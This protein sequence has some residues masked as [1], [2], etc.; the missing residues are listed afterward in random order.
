MEQYINSAVEQF[1]AVL[2]EQI[3]RQKRM[4]S[5]NGA[6][7]YQS[8]PKIIIGICYGDGIGPI[9]SKESK[10]LLEFILKDEIA[11]QQKKNDNTAHI[12]YAPQPN[13]SNPK[14]QRLLFRTSSL[15][16]FLGLLFKLFFRLGTVVVLLFLVLFTLVCKVLVQVTP[17][18]Y[19]LTKDIAFDFSFSEYSSSRAE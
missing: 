3:A 16:A 4:E 14:N 1:K 13:I 10:R 7:D 2:E 18:N 5:D 12:I 15:T 11:S 17:H 9:I 6:T 19:L 8:L